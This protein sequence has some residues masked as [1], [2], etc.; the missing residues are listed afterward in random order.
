M[1]WG[2]DHGRKSRLKELERLPSRGAPILPYLDP[3]TGVWLLDCSVWRNILAAP[4]MAL[5]LMAGLAKR[6]RLPEEVIRELHRGAEGV[7]APNR[8]FEP[9]RMTAAEMGDW[10]DLLDKVWGT[11][12]GEE[13]AGEAA[14]IAVATRRN[15]GLVLD[16]RIGI[17]VA[18]SRNLAV[19]R[20]TN[21]IIAGAASGWWS[22][23]E[24]WNGHRSMIAAGRTMLGPQLWDPSDQPAFEALCATITLAPLVRR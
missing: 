24:A 23:S 19:M 15:W 7:L 3:R 14:C 11:P 2:G 21:L 5:A 22:A 17:N 20:T 4:G 10:I 9:V 1:A 16:D 6:G 8:V 12:N 18:L 13:N